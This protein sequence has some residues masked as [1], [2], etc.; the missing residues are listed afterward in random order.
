MQ[1]LIVNAH[2]VEGISQSYHSHLF[3]QIINLEYFK[4]KLI[5]D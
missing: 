1:Q 3:T 4:N 5:P 2:N